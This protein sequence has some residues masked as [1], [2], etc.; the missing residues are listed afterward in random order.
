MSGAG[1]S[2]NICWRQF[3]SLRH[4]PVYPVPKRR[5]SNPQQVFMNRTFKGV[6]PHGQYCNGVRSHGVT[7]FYNLK[8]G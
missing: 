2:A 3:E 6:E 5:T 7:A 4:P 1:V 8:Y